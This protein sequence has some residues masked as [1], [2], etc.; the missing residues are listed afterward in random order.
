MNLNSLLFA[1][2]QTTSTPPPP[3]TD[4][5]DSGF[6][7]VIAA[8]IAVWLLIAVYLF[9]LNR[10]QESLR[11]EVEQLRQEE[12]ERQSTQAPAPTAPFTEL[13]PKLEVSGT[14]QTPQG[15]LRG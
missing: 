2:G 10:R 3:T 1:L 8:F 11:Q 9:W 14:P 4:Q 6:V 15:N 7:Y 5:V 13:D 12:A